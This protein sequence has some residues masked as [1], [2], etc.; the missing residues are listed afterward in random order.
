MV[1]VIVSYR[2]LEDIA[3]ADACFDLFGNSLEELFYAGFLAL[4]ET[5]VELH[6]IKEILEK[7]LTLEHQNLDRLLFLFLEELIFLKDAE[8]LIFN[9]CKLSINRNAE[10][11]LYTL[12]ATLTG[13]EFNEDVSTITDVKAVTFYQLFVKQNEGSWEARVTFDL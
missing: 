7:N 9:K 3:I 12:S 6:T 4:M 10:A 13:Q 5:S 11:S 2:L 8:L 1:V